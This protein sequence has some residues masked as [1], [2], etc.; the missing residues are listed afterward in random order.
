MN[1]EDTVLFE[2]CLVRCTSEELKLNLKTE[3][4][5]VKDSGTPVECDEPLIRAFGWGG[6]PQG[7]VFW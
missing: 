2:D 4:E 3:L 1:I 6:T 7:P 5:I